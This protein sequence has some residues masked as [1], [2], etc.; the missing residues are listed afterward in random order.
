MFRRRRI[1][2]L[3]VV[4]LLVVGVW[5]GVAAVVNWVG[6]L[7]GGS[8][9]ANPTSSAA[10]NNGQIAACN[11]ADIQ[12]NAYIGDGSS[13]KTTFASGEIPMLWFSVTNNGANTCQLNLGAKEQIFTITS[14]NETIWTSANCNREGLTDAPMALG[15]GELKSSTPSAWFKVRS[16]ASGGCGEDQAKVVTGGASYHLKVS[17][18]GF[19]SNDVQ[20]ILN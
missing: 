8:P 19:T 5:A 3:V 14:G 16:T 7:F 18:G 13:P 9:A 15:S 2:A 4:L 11:S 17:V 10:A 1:F 20:F 6:G 12:V